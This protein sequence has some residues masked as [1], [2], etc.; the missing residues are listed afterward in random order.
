LIDTAEP[1]CE[2]LDDEPKYL[3]ELEKKIE[4][5][6]RNEITLKDGE[7]YHFNENVLKNI[8]NL[9]ETDDIY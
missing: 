9:D 3:K 8:H 6:E 2:A 4:E 1:E 7:W 5:R